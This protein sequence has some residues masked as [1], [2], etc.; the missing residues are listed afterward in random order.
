MTTGVCGW[1]LPQKGRAF[2][3]VGSLWASTGQID[4]VGLSH[5]WVKEILL[6]RGYPSKSF[7]SL[8]F[9]FLLLPRVLKMV[10][11]LQDFTFS[12]TSFQHNFCPL[13]WTE[14]ACSNVILHSYNV[15]NHWP[16]LALT[17]LIFIQIIH[18]WLLYTHQS[19]LLSRISW[20][21]AILISSPHLW[22]LLFLVS[23]SFSSNTETQAFDK[24][25]PMPQVSSPW[26]AFLILAIQ[27][28]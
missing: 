2:L 5:S 27:L 1:E 9:S 8:S 20:S 26:M 10:S 19:F 25:F 4:S 11:T 17:S 6:G 15:S 23:V 12:L 21:R 16:F 22:P 14:T 7:I 24:D 13:L 3:L 18:S 28:R